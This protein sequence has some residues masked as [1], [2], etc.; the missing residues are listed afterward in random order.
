MPDKFDWVA[1]FAGTGEAAQTATTRP[2]KFDIKL[3][4]ADGSTSPFATSTIAG[5]GKTKFDNGILF[6]GDDGRI[7]VNRGRLTGKPV[8]EM[9]E[10][11]NKEAR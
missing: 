1:Y 6:E 4:Y 7:F 2:R 8:E 5:D 11:D 3:E 10:D 9:T